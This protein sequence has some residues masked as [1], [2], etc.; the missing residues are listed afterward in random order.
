MTVFPVLVPSKRKLRGRRVPQHQLWCWPSWTRRIVSWHGLFP[1]LVVL[2]AR[3]DVVSGVTLDESVE[4]EMMMESP[5]KRVAEAEESR[6]AS[7]A[8]RTDSTRS[9]VG[10]DEIW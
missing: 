3:S 6:V 10:L 8:E 7:R 5:R 9:V 1:L 4:Y 2:E